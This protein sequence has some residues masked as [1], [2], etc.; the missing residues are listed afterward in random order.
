MRDKLKSEKYKKVKIEFLS[1]ING[2]LIST[3]LL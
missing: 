2:A 1:G 3:I